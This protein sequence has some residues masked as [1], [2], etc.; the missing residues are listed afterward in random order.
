MNHLKIFKKYIN[1]SKFLVFVL[2][3]AFFGILLF[4]GYVVMLLID[5]LRDG[6][7]LAYATVIGTVVSVMSTFSNGV[8]MFGVKKYLEKSA[9][10]NAVGYDAKT[11]TISDE[12]IKQLMNETM[13]DVKEDDF[14]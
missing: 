11:N 6:F 13:E 4:D 1:F 9:K 7:N 3:L 12:R 8:I 10:E 5:M 14:E 2:V